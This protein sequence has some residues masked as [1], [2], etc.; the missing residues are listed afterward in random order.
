M[1]QAEKNKAGNKILN[2]EDHLANKYGAKGSQARQEFETRAISYY[3]G[4][5]LKAQREKSNLTQAELAERTGTKKSY[6]SRV[7]NG[8]TDIQIST[9]YKL[10]EVGLNKKIKFTIA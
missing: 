4:E 5:L 3:F 8:H 9:L 7:E 1:K 2:W 10:I 6:I